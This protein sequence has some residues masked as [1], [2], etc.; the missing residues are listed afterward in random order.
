MN[1]HQTTLSG[2]LKIDV[3]VIEDDRG[4]FRVPWQREQ[5][6]AAG[7]PDFGPIQW[8]IS[9]SK[10]GVIR[11]I[12][13]EPWDKF[14]HMTYGEATSVIVDLRKES[15]TYGK[16]ELFELNRKSALFVPR[17]MGNSFQVTSDLGVYG[18]LVNAHWKSGLAYQAVDFDD[19]TFNIPWP[20]TGEG[21]I[22]SEKD[23]GN[24]MFSSLS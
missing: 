9:E 22:V 12:H 1:I 14:V 16:Y 24:P 2:V 17:G 5:M 21:Q 6:I 23:R 10:R 18:Y 20:I 15:V 8:N 3:D 11:G 19:P 7:L 13:A 4:S